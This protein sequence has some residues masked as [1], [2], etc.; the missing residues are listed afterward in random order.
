MQICS[1]GPPFLVPGKLRAVLSAEGRESVPTASRPGGPSL[2]PT[3][4]FFPA[5]GLK[6]TQDTPCFSKET[7]PF[8]ASDF[9]FVFFECIF[10]LEDSTASLQFKHQ[11]SR[12]AEGVKKGL[13]R[14]GAHSERPKVARAP[15]AGGWRTGPRYVGASLAEG[16]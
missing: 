12:W 5:W 13:L 8:K 3:F 7:E 15:W 4:T 14:H 11:V 6:G 1:L 9:M 10:K 16:W 2:P